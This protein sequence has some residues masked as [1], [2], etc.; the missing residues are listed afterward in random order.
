MQTTLD[1][2]PKQGKG[3]HPPGLFLL[4]ITEMWERYSYYGIRSFLVLYLT[5]ELISGGLGMSDSQ[6][7]L[8]YG[9]YIGLVYLSPM[10][11]GWITD[12]LMSLRTGVTLGGII[13][14]LGD[15]SL[16]LVQEKWGLY[17]GL[18]LLI[19]GNGFFKPNISTLLGEL[20]E[21]NDKRKD[22]AFTIFYMGINLGGFFAPIV[23]GLLY[24]DFFYSTV[25]GVEHFGFKF[26]FL[27]SSIGMIIGQVL[28]NAL[29]KKY[30]G[31]VGTKKYKIQTTTSGEG[32]KKKP[33]TK[34][35][36]HRTIVIFILAVFVVMFWVGFEQAGASFTLYTRDFIDRTLFGYE[37][38]VAWFQ[39][40]NPL[41]ILLLAPVVSAFWLKMAKT[42]RGD[43]S[44]PTKMAFGLMLLG[45]GFMVLVPAVMMTGS[46]EADI[47]MK[48]SA[49]FMVV[50][51][52]LN[53]LG[54]L[55]L[56]P[57]GL[58][59]VTKMSPA[60]FASALMGVWFLSNAAAN[61]LAGVVAS[62]TTKSGYLEIYAYLGIFAIGLGILLLILTKP[63][64]RLMHMDELER[65]Q[66]EAA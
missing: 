55:C 31:D 46:D 3:K 66:G 51:Y 54:E 42:K 20:Y 26:A 38:P 6:A 45:L 35:E 30:L 5:A 16:F 29:A 40:L 44:V 49:A 18:G 17:L 22:S 27:A 64:Q 59:M 4:F 11:G 43:F 15:F 52:L 7:L 53:T 24:E 14:A 48:A 60:K 28:F 34:V 37:V 36:K 2:P 25:N 8:L 65:E 32:D 63:I 57:I 10:I 61:K 33:L 23:A 50:T 39:S 58:S 19:I 13:M 47:T 9:N 21:K 62:W 12:K 56:S 1:N 41:F